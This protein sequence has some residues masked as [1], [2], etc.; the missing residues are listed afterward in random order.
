M[1]NFYSASNGVLNSAKA[2]ESCI[3]EALASRASL[4]CDLIVFHTTVGHQFQELLEQARSMCPNAKVVGC[5]SAGVIW[6]RGANE[7]LFALS[8]MVM[9][10]D[11][12]Q[13]IAVST[14][15][16]INGRNA[17]DV[18]RSMA[19][20]LQQQQQ[21]TQMIQLLTTGIDIA[22]DQVIAGI[23]SVFGPDIPIFGGTASDN[24]RAENCFQFAD[25]QILENGAIIVGF[26]DPGLRIHSGVHH[27]FSPV[28]MG[29]TVTKVD[30]NRILEIE[31]QPACPS[32]C[33]S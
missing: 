29:Y 24:M 4:D 6:K 7:S 11:D 2:M 1:I 26:A 19:L 9:T 20:D 27:G 3:E 32:S 25:E 33:K 30:G 8:V 17:Y 18:A 16:N 14:N 31:G 22:A 10:T 28:G 21:G 23:E 12:K 5:S 13:E 15:D